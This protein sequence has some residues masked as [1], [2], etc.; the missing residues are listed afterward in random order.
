[1]SPANNAVVASSLL[2]ISFLA[3]AD[4]HDTINLIAEYTL[5]TDS[6]LFRLPKDFDASSFLGKSSKAERVE[7]ASIMMTLDKNYSLQHFHL[8]AGFTDFRHHNFDQLNFTALNYAGR[9]NW[10]FS[11]SVRG[12]FIASRKVGLNDLGETRSL[13]RNLRTDALIEFNTVAELNSAWRLQGAVNRAR[14]S[15]ELAVVEDGDYIMNG[16]EAGVQRSFGSGSELTYKYRRSQGD[17][18]NQASI[19]QTLDRFSDQEHE[20]RLQWPATSKTLVTARLAHLNRHHPNQPARD[21]SGPTGSIGIDWNIAGKTDLRAVLSRGLGSYQTNGTIYAVT[22]RL[23][24]GPRWRVGAHT[25]FNLSYDYSIRNLG[26]I[27]LGIS[28]ATSDRQDKIRIAQFGLA[29]KPRTY[30]SFTLS[31]Q[32]SRRSVNLTGFDYNSNVVNAG[33]QIYF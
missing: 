9:W 26:G 20:I 7:I 23:S 1:M 10:S 21:F 29:W 31:L 12:N 25:T 11:P 30:A 16:V 4:A 2:F 28:D 6:N 8:D 13:V 32:N 22:D 24:I 5:R 19:V 18:E 14:R 17:Y 33:A 3:K 15:N 27:P